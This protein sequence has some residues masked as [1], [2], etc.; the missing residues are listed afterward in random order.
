MGHATPGLWSSGRDPDPGKGSRTAIDF[1]RECATRRR[2]VEQ[3]EEG[4]ES[5]RLAGRC[6]MDRRDM[7]R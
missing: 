5:R 6:V 4:A 1:Q 2:Y 7:G 3:G